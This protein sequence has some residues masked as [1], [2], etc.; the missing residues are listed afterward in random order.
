MVFIAG[1]WINDVEASFRHS[2]IRLGVIGSTILVLIL[3]TAWLVDRDITTS[4]GYLK[5]AMD[6]LA[7]GDLSTAIPGTERQDE[8]GGMASA[9][10]AFKDGMTEAERLRSEQETTKLRAATERTTVLNRMADS[11][12]SQIG[13]LVE[14]L[15]AN[16]TAL[17]ATARSVTGTANQSNQQAATI[18]AAA[19]EASSGL[20]TVA[21]AA[22]ELTA[23]I[24][25]ITRQ[26]AQS[27]RVTGSAVADARRTDAIVRALAAG[28]ERIGA[29]VGLISNIASQTNLLALNAT[30]EAARAGD[31]GKGFAVVA[32]EVKSLA[33]Q[34]GK[35]TEEIAVQ[36]TQIQVATKEAVAAISG[37]ATTIEEVSTIAA[38]IAT[39][40][41]QQGSATSEIA[42]TVQQTS[43]AAQAVTLGIGGVSQ[44]AGETGAAV[45]TFLTA[46]S[47]LSKQAEQLSSEVN[48]FLAG[49]RAA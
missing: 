16:S 24:G 15:S 43:Q 47:D 33:T 21:S 27:A 39:A 48:T 20:H 38:T 6:R 10:L 40:V 28:A 37:I 19:E 7:T 17:E 25:E 42:R 18:A 41:E 3:L 29:V 14:T 31:A 32:S 9:V 2:L 22:E 36:V 44:A 12:R 26:V 8:I 46:A 34:T 30:I 11:F 35:A 4:L 1:S 5:A 45:G 23:S 49:V 13:R